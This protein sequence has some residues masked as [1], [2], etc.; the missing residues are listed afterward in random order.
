MLRET[1]SEEANELARINANLALLTGHR[2][3]MPLITIDPLVYAQP[4]MKCAA[5]KHENIRAADIP[6]D[7][8]NWKAD[9]LGLK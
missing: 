4:A 2:C 6:C 3:A 9:I 1:A 5:A 7:R 8:R